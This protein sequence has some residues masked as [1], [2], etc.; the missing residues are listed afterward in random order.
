MLAFTSLFLYNVGMDQIKIGKFIADR[1]KAKNFTQKQLAELLFIS[2]KTVSKWECG[3]GLPEVSLMLPLC[4]RLEITVNELLLGE[5]ITDTEYKR[6]AEKAM[7]RLVD[8][9][10]RENKKKMWLSFICAIVTVVAVCSLTV[11][12]GYISMSTAARIGILL[13]SVLIMAIGIGGA[14]VLELDA[15]YYQCPHCKMQFVPTM[16]EYIKGAHT[17]TK[18]KLTCPK[19]GARRYCKHIIVRKDK[20]E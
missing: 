16:Y 17:L 9:T 5:L 3:K 7:L 13:F 19:C 18:R 12:A 20:E 10:N 14:A 15:G 1:R 2:E 11:I 4:E 8:E 6:N